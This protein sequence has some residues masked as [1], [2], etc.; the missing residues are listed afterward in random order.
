LLP[1]GVIFELPLLLII[2][3]KVGL[4]SSAFLQSKRKVV[5]VLAFIAGAVISPTPDIFSQVMIA[6]P[7]LAFYEA[8]II[9]LKYFMGN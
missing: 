4:I 2:L 7:L 8:S 3:G 5:L 9:I 6:I 1:F